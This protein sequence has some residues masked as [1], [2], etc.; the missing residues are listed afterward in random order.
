MLFSLP[1]RVAQRHPSQ[2]TD[3]T[4][5]A[6][7]YYHKGLN[8]LQTFDFADLVRRSLACIHSTCHGDETCAHCRKLIKV[9]WKCYINQDALV[10]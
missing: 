4:C 9:I 10:D 3:K 6:C 5:V 8:R 7:V 1:R 2:E